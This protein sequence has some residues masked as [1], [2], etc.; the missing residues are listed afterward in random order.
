M[1]ADSIV[2]VATR[3][4]AVKC[5]RNIVKER[6]YSVRPGSNIK[7]I[8]TSLN[9]EELVIYDDN[10]NGVGEGEVIRKPTP[11]PSFFNRQLT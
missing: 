3:S 2:A 8:H 11:L 5:I 6:R 10:D 1:T 9:I 7:L 4:A